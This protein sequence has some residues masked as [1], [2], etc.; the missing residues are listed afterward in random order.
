MVSFTF[1][2]TVNTKDI[3][4]DVIGEQKMIRMFVHLDG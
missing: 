4:W 3:M 2:M 1:G